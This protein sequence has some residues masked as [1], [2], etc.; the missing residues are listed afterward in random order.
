MIILKAIELILQNQTGNA[1]LNLESSGQ[2]TIESLKIINDFPFYSAKYYGDYKLKEFMNGAIKSPD[3]V[4]PFFEQFFSQLGFPTKLKL[5]ALPE[6]QNGCSAFFCRTAEGTVLIGKNL[7]WK[8]DPLLLLKTAPP[9]GYKSLSMV[10][11]NFCDLFQLG[12]FNHKLL[13][14][15]YVPMDGINESGLVVTMLSV[16][17]GSEYSFSPDKT[18]VGDYNIIRIILD[19][20]KNVDEALT[21]F[22]NYNIMQTGPLPLHYL[23][24]DREKSSIVE[25]SKG[26]MHLLESSQINY[27][28]NFNKLNNPDFRNQRNFCERYGALEEKLE[29]CRGILE[30][31]EA[32]KLLHKVSVYQPEFELPSTIWSI[33]YNPEELEMKIRIGKEPGFYTTCLKRE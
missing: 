13:L 4:I 8:K 30:V 33:L 26:E 24:A 21:V 22:K 7:D 16:H 1:R 9:E 32:K 3:H 29:N 25:F 14:A 5:S 10:N 11:L 31:S 20:C 2:K 27:L 19:S 12:S 6:R 23:I 28:T 17:K 18:S 15:P